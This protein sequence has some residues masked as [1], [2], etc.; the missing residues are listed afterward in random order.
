MAKINAKWQKPA[1]P[2]AGF[3]FAELIPRLVLD[4][5]F[6]KLLFQTWIKFLLRILIFH[7][8]RKK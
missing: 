8:F 2:Q 6:P 5:S 1:S 7:F 3:W 4:Q